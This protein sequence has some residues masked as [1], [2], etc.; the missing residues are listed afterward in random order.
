MTTLIY[1]SIHTRNYLQQNIQ[2]NTFMMVEH[3]C[4]YILTGQEMVYFDDFELPITD[5]DDF[6]SYLSS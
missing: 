1:I 2:I 3:G 5:L 4:I 6:E